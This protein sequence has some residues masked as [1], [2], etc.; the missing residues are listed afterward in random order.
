ML[1]CVPFAP[2][3]ANLEEFQV[4]SSK[5]E[6]GKGNHAKRTQFAEVKCAKRTQFLASR[7]PGNARLCKT[8]PI[9]PAGPG[10]TG[11]EGRGT[12]GNAQNEP[13]LGEVSNAK[14]EVG[15]SSVRNKANF[16]TVPDEPR[17]G[18][19]RTRGLPSTRRPLVSPGA[20]RRIPGRLTYSAGE[21][22]MLAPNPGPISG[23]IS[24]WRRGP[25]GP[26]RAAGP[27]GGGC[28]SR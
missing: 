9:C 7:A 27:L 12:R 18:G 15:G 1:S 11:P 6:A 26:H 21:S 19:R 2:N 22:S 25:V 20:Y 13:N 4:C 14:F 3:K 5:C 10:G 8:K 16:P 24:P 23:S 28:R 17:R